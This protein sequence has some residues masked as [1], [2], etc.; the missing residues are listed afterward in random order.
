MYL[1]P[2]PSAPLPPRPPTLYPP[3]PRPPTL[4]PPP[5]PASHPLSPSPPGL[6]PSV[7]LP[8]GLPP[9][10][11]LAPG[12]PPSA[13]PPSPPTARAHTAFPVPDPQP[14]PR[15]LP[16]LG[17]PPPPPPRPAAIDDVYREKELEDSDDARPGW[18]D[19]L[20]LEAYRRQWNGLRVRV[21]VH[22]GAGDI[23]LDPVSRGYDYYGT[24]VN[25]AARVESVCHGGQIGATKAVY[26]AL[27]G[28]APDVEWTDLGPQ[29][30]RG[31]AEPVHIVQALPCGALA[32]RA[33]P[34]L[35]LDRER[36]GDAAEES[37]ASRAGSAGSGTSRGTVADAV[38]V[39]EQHP[40]VHKGQVSAA[41]LRLHYN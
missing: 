34:P 9:S 3:P 13:P 30:L 2:P 1:H 25:T 12:L 22:Y 7:P 14:R 35:R 29:P 32:A 15:P 6:P 21:G 11:P 40:L 5:P 8:P 41:E 16:R 24:V 28:R 18:P 33:F 39:P 37:A 38:F 20:P 26:D 31:L 27:R 36:A 19:P 4:R 10:V 23:K 17:P